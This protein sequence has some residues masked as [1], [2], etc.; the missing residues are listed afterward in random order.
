MAVYFRNGGIF[1]RNMHFVAALWNIGAG[2]PILIASMFTEALFPIFGMS[3]PNNLMWL[4]FSLSIIIVWGIGY[5]L[6][7]RNISR[8]HW[9]LILGILV[10]AAYFFIGLIYLMSGEVNFL[11]LST[12]IVDLIFVALF[13]EFLMNYKKAG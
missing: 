7:S 6:V 9:I 2:L 11:F 4:Q 8:N 5:Y 12:G 13:I 1:H 10:K 3:V